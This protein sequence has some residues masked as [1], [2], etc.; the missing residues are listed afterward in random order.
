ML[1]SRNVQLSERSSTT[2]LRCCASTVP[3]RAARSWKAFSHSSTVAIQ[4]PPARP[5]QRRD[6]TGLGDGTVG[7]VSGPRHAVAAGSG[8]EALS[9][10]QPPQSGG[11]RVPAD[12]A[13]APTPGASAPVVDASIDES[14]VDE[15][16]A[17]R[18]DEPEADEAVVG[19]NEPGQVATADDP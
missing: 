6:G 4:I 13:Y 3:R 5:R 9:V 7:S 15:A 18:A 14:T 10:D 1:R 2:F 11:D 12:A 16:P 8:G 17:D 19:L